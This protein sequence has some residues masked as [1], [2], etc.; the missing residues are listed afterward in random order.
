VF[1]LSIYFLPKVQVQKNDTN[2]ISDFILYKMRHRSYLLKDLHNILIRNER[3]I[4]QS[5]PFKNIHSIT[6][7]TNQERF[8]SKFCHDELLKT[9]HKVIVNSGFLTI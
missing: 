9:G 6:E 8:K 3:K 4:E 1:Q 5:F 7:G 2:R